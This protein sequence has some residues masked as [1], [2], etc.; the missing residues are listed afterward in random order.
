MSEDPPRLRGTKAGRNERR[1]TL[2]AYLNTVGAALLAI[3]ALPS[4]LAVVSGTRQVGS[5]EGLAALVFVAVSFILHVAAQA[6]V[7]RLED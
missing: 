5:G 7:S 2:G 6:V 1:K 3:G 4:A